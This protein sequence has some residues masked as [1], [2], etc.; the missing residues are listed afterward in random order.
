MPISL[1]PL[2]ATRQALVADQDI[3]PLFSRLRSNPIIEFCRDLTA[4][5]FKDRPGNPGVRSAVMHDPLALSILIDPN[6]VEFEDFRVRVELRDG[7][8]RGLTRLV[9]D[10]PASG[11]GKL[12]AATKVD[13]ALFLQIF[14]AGIERA[15]QLI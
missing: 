3:A 2:D 6:V 14:L 1:V 7:P 5:Y 8:E 13:A 11:L 12:R 15:S 4:E 10:D 9:S